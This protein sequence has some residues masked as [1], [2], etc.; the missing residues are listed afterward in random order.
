MHLD[1]MPSKA[2]LQEI[3]TSWSLCRTIIACQTI[4]RMLVEQVFIILR[5]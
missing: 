3:L 5:P 2:G 1:F 4:I